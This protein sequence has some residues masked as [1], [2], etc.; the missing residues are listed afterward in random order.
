M[1]VGAPG[2]PPPNPQGPPPPAPSNGA[3]KNLGGG[4]QDLRLNAPRAADAVVINFPTKLKTAPGILEFSTK[5]TYIQNFASPATMPTSHPPV[6][7]T[8]EGVQVFQQLRARLRGV[9]FPHSRWGVCPET[10][11]GLF[12]NHLET[13]GGWFAKSNCR[14]GGQKMRSVLAFLCL[15]SASSSIIH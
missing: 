1:Y 9:L 7:T 13:R 8:R 3:Q 6:G 15:R 2:T 10:R 11:T 5:A 14:R 4:G 12:R